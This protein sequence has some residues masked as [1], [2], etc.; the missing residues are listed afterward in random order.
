M[1]GPE[2]ATVCQT[3]CVR[4]FGFAGLSAGGLVE[5][6]RAPGPGCV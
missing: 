3:A 1:S 5:T 6:G 4:A 2:T